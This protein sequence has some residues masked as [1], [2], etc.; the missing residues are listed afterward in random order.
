MLQ[1]ISQQRCLE[2]MQMQHIVQQQYQ[3]QQRDKIQLQSN[4]TANDDTARQNLMVTNA[5]ARKVL[6]EVHKF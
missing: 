5:L 2:Q 4:T 1:K 3:Q 6:K